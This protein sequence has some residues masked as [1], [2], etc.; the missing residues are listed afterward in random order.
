M[1]GRL[2][3]ASVLLNVKCGLLLLTWWSV[4][5]ELIFETG[6]ACKKEVVLIWHFV[7][8]EQRVY[9]YRF[10]FACSCFWF[11]IKPGVFEA[12]PAIPQL[13]VI[14]DKSTS[15]SSNALMLDTGFSYASYR[16]FMSGGSDPREL[17]LNDLSG[18]GV[19]PTRWGSPL[20]GEIWRR[21]INAISG[22]L[23]MHTATFPRFIYQGHP[24]N[25]ETFHRIY[26]TA[27]ALQTNAYSR[28]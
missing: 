6:H 17:S 27:S 9:V 18:R 22:C 20:K 15:I 21:H 3:I 2:I 23:S 28:V 25:S 1:N 5:V 16:L 13:C 10:F 14:K 11:L 26:C 7:H 4:C 8:A 19:S 24:Q 12:S